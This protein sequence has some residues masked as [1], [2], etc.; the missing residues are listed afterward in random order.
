[1]LEPL[2]AEGRNERLPELAAQVLKADPQVIVV[3]TAPATRILQQATATIPIVMWAVGDPVEYGLVASLAK[4]GGNVTG[5]SYM[6]NEVAG[7]LV[8]LLKE[9]VPAVTSVA[10][11]VNPSNPGMMPYLRAVQAVA[12]VLRVRVQTVEVRTPDDFE[13]AFN[14]IARDRTEAI[15]LSPEQL[16]RSQRKR[17]AE[18]A[19]QRRLPLLLHSA[20]LDGGLLSYAP[21]TGEVPRVVASYVDRILKGA[22]PADLPVQQP[23]QFELGVSLK[24]AKALGLTIPQTL[25]LRADRV[26][27]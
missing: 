17:V 1:V 2:S 25:L 4:P 19:A 23:T 13:R 10:V 15:I 22:K 21:K 5:T 3:L 8:E 26:I 24:A 14:A 20:L 9:A 16:V 12:D 7:K 11:F 18:F 6:V 27:E